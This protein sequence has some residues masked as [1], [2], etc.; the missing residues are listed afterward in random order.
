MTTTVL[1]DLAFHIDLPRLMRKLRLKEGSRHV[2]DLQVLAGEAE[3]IARPKV[4]YSLA[5]VQEKGE[6]YVI[7]SGVR[8]TSRV[9]RVNVEAAYRIFPYVATCGTELAAWY[10]SQGDLLRQFWAESI[11]ELALHTA[12]HALRGH[13][14]NRYRLDKLSSM[15]PGSLSDWPLQQQQH[16]FALL[17]DVEQSVGVRLTESLL[18]VPTKSVSGVFFPSESS[19]QSCQLCPREQCPGRRAEY[20][21]D[22]YGRKYRT[23]AGSQTAD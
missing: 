23:G 9:L 21:P 4:V 5:Y 3:R 12:W 16:V 10:R 11:G 7:A 18:M 8:L 2:R 14:V 1:K 6:D 17:D 19:F 15:A 13:L 22:L 20:D